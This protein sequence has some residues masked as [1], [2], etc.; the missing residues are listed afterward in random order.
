MNRGPKPGATGEAR[1][2][3]NMHQAWG[4]NAPIWI[5]I[6]AQSCDRASLAEIGR[7]VGYSGSAISQAINAKYPG[8]M[9][10]LEKAVRGSLL[11]QT[12]ACEIL[13]LIPANLCLSTQR[14]PFSTA[15][16]QA[17]KLS[18]ACP[19]CPHRHGG[20]HD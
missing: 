3:T 15:S 1:H 7:K 8:D 14:Q 16:P 19:N 18:R 4:D 17:V 20:A 12:I 2:E 5:V 10:A 11:A 13:G 9:G 6:L